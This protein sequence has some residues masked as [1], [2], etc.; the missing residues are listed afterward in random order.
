MAVSQVTTWRKYTQQEKWEYRA[1]ERRR[2]MKRRWLKEAV[3]SAI[4]NGQVPNHEYVKLL[5][6]D[7]DL[8]CPHQ[9]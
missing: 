1:R 2:L 9:S 5:G 8:K 7:G 3:F 6:W 4:Y